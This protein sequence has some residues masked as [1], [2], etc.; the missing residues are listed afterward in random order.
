M[1]DHGS[2]KS[3]GAELVEKTYERPEAGDVG[4]SVVAV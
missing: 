1:E 2:A 4:F 3:A